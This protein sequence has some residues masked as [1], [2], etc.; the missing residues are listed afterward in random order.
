MP[1]KGSVVAPWAWLLCG[2]WDLPGP[3][4]EPAFPALHSR[5]LTTGPP[6][7]SRSTF[8]KG[9]YSCFAGKNYPGQE[10]KKGNQLEAC[11]SCPVTFRGTLEFLLWKGEALCPTSPVLLTALGG[12]QLALFPVYREGNVIT[13]V[14]EL[15]RG[16]TAVNDLQGSR[17]A[18]PDSWKCSHSAPITTT[19]ACVPAPPQQCQ[20][21]E[22]KQL[23]FNWALVKTIAKRSR[24]RKRSV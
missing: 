11:R 17:Q 16:H 2:L 13:Q 24:R 1:L 18:C 23:A 14:N 15:A 12:G 22:G 6:G 19:P 7:K 5:V 10:Q 9:H 3:G 8:I 21:T 4:I 20:P